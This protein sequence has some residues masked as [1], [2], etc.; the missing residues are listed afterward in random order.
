MVEVAKE[1]VEAMDRR[2][3]LVA[4]AEMVL[5]ELTGRVTLWLQQFGDGRVL[6]RKTFLGPW[7]A[8]LEEAGSQ[9]ALAGD[10]G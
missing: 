3:E 4:V 2:Q 5:A 7:Q 1:H 9:R 10:E 6:L 8:H